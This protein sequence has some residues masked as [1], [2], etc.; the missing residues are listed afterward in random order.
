[1]NKIRRKLTRVKIR[2]SNLVFRRI[3][4]PALS[5]SRIGRNTTSGAADSGISIDDIYKNTPLGANLFG[6]ALDNFLLQLPAVK[7]TQSKKD[8]VVKVLANEVENNNILGKTTKIIDIA[9]GPARYLVSFLEKNTHYDKDVQ[10]LCIDNDGE[11]VSYGNFLGRNKPIRFIKANVF[12]LGTLKRFS[13]KVKWKGNI[14][15]CTGF[16][17]LQN[18]VIVQGL[19]KEIYDFMEPGSLLL[20]TSQANN[21]SKTLMKKIGKRQNGVDWRMHFRPPAKLRKW[22][23][24]IGYRDV[25]ISLDG[26]GMYEYCTARKQC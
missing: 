17:E 18:D 12:K 2:L 1:M 6:K 24:D 15:V 3:V 14:I 8:I 23:L 10:I 16:F 13:D 25:I 19:L 4:I 9:S 26:W 11:S 21:P 20:F 22:L 7:A 5:S